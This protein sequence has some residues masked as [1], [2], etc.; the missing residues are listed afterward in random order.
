MNLFSK[1]TAFV[2]V[3]FALSF[4]AD[5]AL[6]VQYDS[7]AN[8]LKI[9]M[10]PDSTVAVVSCRLYYFAGSMYECS[11]TTGLSHMFEHMMFKG[12]K[13]LGTSDYYAE[14]KW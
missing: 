6:P 4:S 1:V 8:G 12:T 5:I 9:I 14:K 11:G 13:K 7:L 2:G 10:V 3:F